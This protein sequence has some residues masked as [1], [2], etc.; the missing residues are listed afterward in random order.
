MSTK[1]GFYK[2]RFNWFYGQSAIPIV[3]ILTSIIELLKQLLKIR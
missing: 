2:Y 3:I 1:P